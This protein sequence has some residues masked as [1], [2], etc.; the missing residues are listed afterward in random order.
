MKPRFWKVVSSNFRIAAGKSI[1]RTRGT[2]LG[3]GAA[4]CTLEIKS[5]PDP[6]SQ[7]QETAGPRPRGAWAPFSG[8]FAARHAIIGLPMKEAVVKDLIGN[9]LVRLIH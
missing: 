5:Q 3:R 4:V 2:S 8:T 7:R 1:W 9:N 6:T